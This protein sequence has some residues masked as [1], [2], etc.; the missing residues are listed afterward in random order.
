M[1]FP[2]YRKLENGLSFYKLISSKVFEE[3]QIVGKKCFTHR[4]EAKQYPEFLKIQDML[5]L[6][7]PY[8]DCVAEDYELLK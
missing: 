5:Q 8:L 6:K 2:I 1:E 7:A 3:K 4:V